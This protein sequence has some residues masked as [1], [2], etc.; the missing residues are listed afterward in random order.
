MPEI[1]SGRS[2]ASVF[3]RC[4]GG[5]DLEN[6]PGNQCSI[7][8]WKQ[9]KV[10]RLVISLPIAVLGLALVTVG[11]N[12]QETIKIGVI[13]PLTGSVA[14][15]GTTDVNGSKLALDEIN[16]KGGV[17]GHRGRPVPSGELGQ[18]GGKTGPT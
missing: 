15:N 3:W 7:A 14:Y 6:Q 4:S 2:F 10:M 1:C 13:Q 12:G 17:L 16:A 18:C 5:A 9:E 8:N 11:A